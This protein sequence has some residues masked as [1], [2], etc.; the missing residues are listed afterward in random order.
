[1]PVLNIDLMTPDGVLFEGNEIP[2]DLQNKE[3]VSRLVNTLGLPRVTPSDEPIEYSLEIANQ[4]VKLQ[5]G[6]TLG[7][8]GATNGDVIRLVSSHRIQ[9]PLE[10]QP[11]PEPVAAS[12]IPAT[13]EGAPAANEETDQKTAG[14][15]PVLVIRPTSSVTK[16]IRRLKD[17]LGLKTEDISVL[18]HSRLETP[19]PA[20]L[21]SSKQGRSRRT[22]ML[23]AMLIA[24]CL[25]LVFAIYNKKKAVPV[26][27]AS[28]I[29]RVQ[30]P[31]PEPTPEPTMEPVPAPSIIPM[32]TPKFRPRAIPTPAVSRPQWR[33]KPRPVIVVQNVVAP[34]PE[35][36]K[37]KC[38][39]WRK[40][41]VGCKKSKKEKK[42]EGVGGVVGVA[43]SAA[44]SNGRSAIRRG[45]NYPTRRI[46][47]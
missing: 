19:A 1:M 25:F 38:G 35:E 7:D 5:D 37:K 27:Q 11:A 23:G 28:E 6:Q 30:A 21:Q 40:I 42:E 32:P 2:D 44:V 18:N 36:P 15:S 47:P 9:K 34:P 8:A 45:I 4:G 41:F 43:K 12:G 22:A 3:L 10:P 13:G 14:D 24:G 33:P 46:I 39:F 26:A 29:A 16:T 31:T 17:G 20:G